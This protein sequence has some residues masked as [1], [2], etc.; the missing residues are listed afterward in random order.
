[1]HTLIVYISEVKIIGRAR[2]LE[3]E[4]TFHGDYLLNGS[5]VVWRH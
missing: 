3:F 2:V 5:S 4:E 1:M